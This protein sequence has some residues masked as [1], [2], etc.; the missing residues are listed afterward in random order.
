MKSTSQ[1]P[2]LLRA[3]DWNEICPWLLL[4]KCLRLGV[5]FRLLILMMIHVWIGLFLWGNVFLKEASP[6]GP[7]RE[8]LGVFSVIHQPW[9]EEPKEDVL[10]PNSMLDLMEVPQRQPLPQR[11]W[12]WK[13]LAGGYLFFSSTLLY[14]MIGR[15]T[16]VKVATGIR[17]YT[18]QGLGLAIRRFSSMLAA[19]FF[20]VLGMGVCVLPTWLGSFLPSWMMGVTTPFI[21]LLDVLAVF[22]VV[23]G[24]LGFPLVLST[25]MTENTDCFDGLSR[26]YAYTFQRPL[27]YAFYVAVACFWGFLGYMAMRILVFLTLGLWGICLGRELPTEAMAWV[28]FWSLSLGLLPWAFL[29][30]YGCSAWTGIYMLLR[31]DVDAVELDE[32]WLENPQGVPTPQLPKLKQG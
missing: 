15:I 24:I 9:L 8:M 2:Y 26:A 13:V 31:R 18:H 10:E 21:L 16:A 29:L 12:W 5:S 30:T 23:G 19:M 3:L 27:R 7:F 1:N 28:E 20:L 14:M 17:P 22:V 25:L 6:E 32:V 4:T 11:P